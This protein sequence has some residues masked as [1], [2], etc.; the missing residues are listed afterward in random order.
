MISDMHNKHDDR[1]YAKEAMSLKAAGHELYHICVGDESENYQD[2]NGIHIIQI[3]RKQHFQN[4]ILNYLYKKLFVKNIYKQILADCRKIN[5]DV[6]HLHDHK[7]IEIVT[8]LKKEVGAK[9][10]YDIHDPFFLNMI[11]Y[12]PPGKINKLIY[13]LYSRQIKKREKKYLPHYDQLITTEENL[14]E[15]YRNRYGRKPKVIYNYTTLTL[16]TQQQAQTAKD[17]DIVY[18]GAITRKR[19]VFQIL[20]AARIL[21]DEGRNY[22]TAF[23]GTIRGPGLRNE[24][25][26]YLNKHRLHERVT[27]VG[28]VPY[29]EIEQ[30]YRKAKVGLAV[31]QD[32]PTHHIIMQI[33][34][35]EYTAMGIPMVGSD[36]GHVKRIIETD[37]SGL[38]CRPD[39]PKEIAAC[40]DR[41][42]SDSELYN[43]LKDNAL[44]AAPK[45]RWERMEKKLFRL[46]EELFDEK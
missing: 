32:I 10:I 40:I 1:I 4:K 7:P 2:E 21:R 23:V 19:S 22:S 38:L 12:A 26:T 25:E 6:Y 45:Y 3:Q 27:F 28:S 33:K 16:D 42:L 13:K 34:L 5:A 9:L 11:D 30:E 46:Y 31:F 37:Q 15:Y 14:A 44:K 43:R 24:I 18:V 35:F 8:K 41:L 36:F 29:S 17:Y 39:S 20:E